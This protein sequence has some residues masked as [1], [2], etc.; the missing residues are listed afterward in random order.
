MA[1]IEM[2]K[3]QI[4]ELNEK[5]KNKYEVFFD[6]DNDTF[7]K[8]VLKDIGNITTLSKLSMEELS[9]IGLLVGVDGSVAKVGGADPHYVEIYQALAKPSKGENIFETSVFSPMVQNDSDTGNRDVMLARIEMK[10][11]IKAIDT[12]NPKIIMMDGGLIRYKINDNELFD[13][14]VEKC[15]NNNILL[16]GVIKDI[17]TE[18]IARSLEKLSYFDRELL[19]GRLYKGEMLVIN[20]EC[21]NKFDDAGLVSAFIRGSIDSMIIGIDVLKEYREQVLK[22]GELVY[23]LIPEHSRG[24]P[25][26]LDI[27]D[28]EVKI[29]EKTVRSILEEYLDR[30]IYRRFFV[31][32]REG[33]TL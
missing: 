9:Q 23:S 21:N 7:R 27:V 18:I 5:L 31:S 6:M 3:A 15:R 19:Y 11:A 24:V 22:M 14:L 29:S 17:K 13:I 12:I 33:R 25:Y 20:D 28:A 2:M 4:Q 8:E 26:W 32:E 10:A 1:N 16:M 30:D